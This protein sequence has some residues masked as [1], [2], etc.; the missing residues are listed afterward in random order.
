M[1][2]SVWEV[3]LSGGASDGAGVPVGGVCAGG[4]GGFF[5]KGGS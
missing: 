1:G 3:G 4:E 5:G 2:F